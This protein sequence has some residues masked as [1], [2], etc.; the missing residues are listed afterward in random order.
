MGD[1]PVAFRGP[2]LYLQLEERKNAAWWACDREKCAK[3][4]RLTS[5]PRRE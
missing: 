2:P 4:H 1:Y 5:H 3:K